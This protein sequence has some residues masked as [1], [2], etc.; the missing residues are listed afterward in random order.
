MKQGAGGEG[1]GA[2]SRRL[3]RVREAKHYKTQEGDIGPRE[4]PRFG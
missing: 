1:C 2:V 4:T 3:R